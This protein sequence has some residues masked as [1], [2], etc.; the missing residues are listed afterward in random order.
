MFYLPNNSFWEEKQKNEL[1]DI[2]VVRHVLFF[3]KG[4]SV[5]VNFFFL[6]MVQFNSHFIFFGSDIIRKKS[7]QALLNYCETW[8]VISKCLHPLAVLFSAVGC[9]VSAGTA[10]PP[11]R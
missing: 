1:I 6:N 9:W 8:Q 3:K 10:W 2:S 4:V 7:S 11:M 5:S